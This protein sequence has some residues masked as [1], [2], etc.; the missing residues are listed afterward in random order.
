M[1]CALSC[2]SITHTVQPQ[3]IRMRNTIKKGSANIALHSQKQK[4]PKGPKGFWKR[5]SLLPAALTQS[6]QGQ[7]AVLMTVSTLHTS[8]MK[9]SFQT[10]ATKIHRSS[11]VQ[12]RSLARRDQWFYTM[13]PRVSRWQHPGQ[14]PNLP[15]AQGRSLVM[16]CLRPFTQ[17]PS[18]YQLRP[19]GCLKSRKLETHGDAS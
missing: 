6:S 18:D 17:M 10:L 8:L 12:N 3:K 4:V 11:I 15:L 1:C 14:L 5:Q 13:G 16:C 7:T 2:R 19:Q 9:A